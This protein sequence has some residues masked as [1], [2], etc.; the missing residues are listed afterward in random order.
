MIVILMYLAGKHEL[1]SLESSE[2]SLSYGYCTSGCSQQGFN[3]QVHIAAQKRS[4]A[5][6]KHDRKN[7]HLYM[8][9]LIVGLDVII[10]DLRVLRNN[11]RDANAVKK[12]DY[13]TKHGGC[14]RETHENAGLKK[15]IYL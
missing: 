8:V 14:N 5:H 1:Q 3:K 11:Q 12:D 10:V 13:S 7:N 15:N 2:M 6:D 4:Y 9:V